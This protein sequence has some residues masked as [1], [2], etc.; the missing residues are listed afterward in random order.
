MDAEKKTETAREK[1]G[2]GGTGEIESLRR[3]HRKSDFIVWPEC[4]MENY[5]EIWRRAFLAKEGARTKGLMQWQC[6]KI[7]G[8]PR[9]WKGINK[10]G[11]ARGYSAAVAK[12]YTVNGTSFFI[13]FFS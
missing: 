3:L 6:L 9:C 1:R 2:I 13:L 12:T 7:P 8:R 10:A 5:E 4:Y 11:K